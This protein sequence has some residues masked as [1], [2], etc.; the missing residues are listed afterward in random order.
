MARMRN[1]SDITARKFERPRVD[2]G[3]V[4]LKQ[5]INHE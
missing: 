3:I 4:K 5:E 1:Q 2:Y